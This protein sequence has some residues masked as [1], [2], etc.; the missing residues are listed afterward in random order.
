MAVI[1]VVDDDRSIITAF[2]RFLSDEGHE[3]HTAGTAADGLAALVELKPDLV[4]MDVRM[5]GTNGLQALEEMRRLYPDLY[6]VIMTAYGTSQ[7]SIDAIRA[8]AFDYLAK[9]LD[10][11]DLRAVID[12]ALAS[13]QTSRGSREPAPEWGGTERPVYL[14]GNS[15]GMLAVYKLIGRLATNDVPALIV[16]ERGTG[17]QLVAE[18]IHNNSARR[19]QPFAALDCASLTEDVVEEIFGPQ[20]GTVLLADVREMPAPLQVRLVRAMNEQQGRA[21][22]TGPKLTARVLASTDRDLIE[23]VRQ[24]R[25]NR[26]LH[27]TLSVISIRVP[28]LRE[29]RDDIPLLVTHL[30]QR[31]SAELHRHIRGVDPEA[32]QRLHEHAWPGNVMELET[33]LKRACVLARA[34]IVTAGDLGSLAA[35][36]T[37]E[38][39]H[40]DGTLRTAVVAALHE[41]IDKNGERGGSAFHDVVDQV[42]ATLVQEALSMTHG[43]QV[44]AAEML[45]VNRATLRKKMGDQS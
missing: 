10:L 18:T 41:H 37:R 9:P 25:F 32:A 35:E 43:N 5:P 17:K 36:T 20:P 30:V 33:V 45:G 40:I 38:Y 26:E 13:Q 12:K 19:D 29:R 39:T 34:D 14:V 22:A 8:G 16:G 1:L 3:V 7:T 15:P 21:A 24:G 27:D 44:K 42:E 2:K 6:I 4:F 28:P 31:L 23:D 11:D